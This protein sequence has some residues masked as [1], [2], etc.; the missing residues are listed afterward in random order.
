M[1]KVFS[2][3]ESIE[4]LINSPG[5]G[6]RA[7]EME[8]FLAASDSLHIGIALARERYGLLGHNSADS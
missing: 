2:A 4:Q 7:G 6:A 3:L 8:A 5:R 1:D